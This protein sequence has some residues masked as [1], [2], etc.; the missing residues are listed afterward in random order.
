MSHRHD[1]GLSNGGILYIRV[2]IGLYIDLDL[3]CA[4]G[5]YRPFMLI[6]TELQ[7]M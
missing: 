3:D 2:Y 4:L 6:V 1:R 5:S 7:H